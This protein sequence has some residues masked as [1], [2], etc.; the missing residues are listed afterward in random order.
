MFHFNTKNKHELIPFNSLRTTFH[1]SK[2][3]STKNKL[4]T[5][6][7]VGIN[8]RNKTSYDNYFRVCICTVCGC[9]PVI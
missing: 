5:V 3:D 8:H 4:Q 6:A 1:F 7:S 2:L 9:L